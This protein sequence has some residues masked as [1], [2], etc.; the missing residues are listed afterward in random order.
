MAFSSLGVYGTILAGWASNSFYA[1]LGGLRASAQMISYEVSFGLALLPVII[2]SSSF[3]LRDVVLSQQ[4]EWNFLLIF[5]SAIVFFIS[6]LAETNRT[7]FD[8]P[9]AEGELVAGFNVEYSA[10][11]FALFFLAEYSNIIVMSTLFVILYMGGWYF[12]FLP[13]EF[14]FAFKICLVL[15]LFI[16]VRA[17]LPRYRYDQL[18]QLGWKII[19][20]FTMGYFV[21]VSGTVL[22][23]AQFI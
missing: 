6:L 20:P 23:V 3:D 19:L 7:P 11:F 15:V 5:P 2:V 10:I 17:T 22:T 9:E 21:F 13:F 16:W 4:F 14:S 1:F 8:L 18:I 12:P